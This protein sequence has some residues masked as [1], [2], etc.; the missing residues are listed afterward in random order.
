MFLRIYI[1]RLSANDADFLLREFSKFGA[2]AK[3]AFGKDDN[4]SILIK[5]EGEAEDLLK[6]VS[7]ALREES[8][9]I[10]ITK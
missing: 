6:S 7:V 5:Q 9:R 2:D 8:F 3:M 10:D 1:E 4:H